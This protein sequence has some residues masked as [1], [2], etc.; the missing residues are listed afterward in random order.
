MFSV[1]CKVKDTIS[2]AVDRFSTKF[3][4][5][6]ALHHVLRAGNS[7]LPGTL[8]SLLIA[9]RCLLLPWPE[10]R[11]GTA[12]EPSELSF[13]KFLFV[14]TAGPS[15]RPLGLSRRSA[16]AR[17]LGLR[18]RILLG[19]WM[20]VCCVLWCSGLCDELIFVQR[21]PTDWCVVVCGLETSWMR[22]PWPTWGRNGTE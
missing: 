18:V 14:I 7:A 3:R 1:G 13:F 22:R 21:S 19:A 4:P 8:P 20:F 5:N 2:C 6:A 12:W 15:G 11:E 16:A 10:G 17:L 9:V